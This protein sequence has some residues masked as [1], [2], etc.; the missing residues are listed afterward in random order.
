[1]QAPRQLEPLFC[2]LGPH[3]LRRVGFVALG[4]EPRACQASALTND[5]HPITFLSQGGTK[6]PVPTLDLFHS[7]GRLLTSYPP[8]QSAE[9]QGLQ[10]C[11]TT[12]C[13]GNPGDEDSIA[14]STPTPQAPAPGSLSFSIHKYTTQQPC[15]D[16]P[17]GQGCTPEPAFPLQPPRGTLRQTL[18]GQ[19]Q[20]AV[21]RDLPHRG[22]LDGTCCCQ[23]F[24]QALT[25]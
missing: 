6:L 1:M 20:P 5:L 24:I 14:S 22:R 9:A 19:Q 17:Q 10:A 25:R 4:I 12:P 16:I 13:S 21:P 2:P 11:V 23:L 3:P 18:S 15:T 7:P 8:P